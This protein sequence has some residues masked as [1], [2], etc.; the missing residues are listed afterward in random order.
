MLI[1]DGKADVD[2]AQN[3]GSTPLYIAA[4]RGHTEVVKLLITDG[5]A[6]V[7]TARN[8]GCTP[9]IMAKQKGHQAIVALLE[10]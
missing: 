10:Q 8:D 3:T 6:A 2:K 4:G 5:E 7:D 1:A 9:L